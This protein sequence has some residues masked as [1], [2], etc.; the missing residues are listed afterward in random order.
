MNQGWI[1]LHR[2]LLDWEWFDD[3]NCTRLFLYCLLKANHKDQKWKGLEIKRGSFFT[4]LDT[5]KSETGLTVSQIRTAI[6]K[7]EM[8]GELTSKSQAGGRMIAVVSYDRYQGDDRQNDTIIAEGSQDDDKRVTANKN[9]KKEKNEINIKQVVD[10]YHEL[11]PNNTKVGAITSKRKSA[12]N[13]FF[14]KNKLNEEKFKQYL[15][16]INIYCKWMTKPYQTQSGNTKKN[17]FDYFIS[18]RCYQLVKD[19]AATNGQ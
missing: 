12:V 5:L 6:R 17:G 15:K 9:D 16:A 13:S 11:L 2:S 3:A 1:K 14:K 18:D 10:D 8:T 4:G 19:E 7:L